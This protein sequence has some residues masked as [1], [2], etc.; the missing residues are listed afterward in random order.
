[1]EWTVH[2]E[3]M[4]YD[5]EWMRVALVDVELPSGARFEHHVL[6]MPAQAAGVIVDD[7][8]QWRAP[9]LQQRHGL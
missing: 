7:A 2:G 1:M 6:R 5:N 4:V 3:R 9:G 8:D